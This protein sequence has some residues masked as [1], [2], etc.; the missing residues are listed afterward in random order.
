M[1][2]LGD[3]LLEER[4]RRG[5]TLKEVGEG[6]GTSGQYISQLERGER[7]PSLENYLGLIRFFGVEF[8]FFLDEETDDK[9]II[10]NEIRSL[11]EKRKWDIG[12]L[13]DQSGVDFFRIGRAENGEIELSEEELQKIA[14]ALDVDTDYF[15]A[16]Y[17]YNIAKILSGAKALGLNEKQCELL[18][19]FIDV[20]LKDNKKAP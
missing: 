4:K 2:Q 19:Q 17:E 14:V 7:K 11:R 9:E 5:Y 20:S 10:G 16:R 1:S 12:D 6:I 18:L 3:K 13:R 15:K 8:G